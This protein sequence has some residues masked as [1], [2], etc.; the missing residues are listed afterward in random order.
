MEESENYESEIKKSENWE[1]GTSKAPKGKSYDMSRG[2]APSNVDAKKDGPGGRYRRT[3]PPSAPSNKTHS[4]MEE[5]DGPGL[6]E[7]IDSL[8][9]PNTNVPYGDDPEADNPDYN[10]NNELGNIA[11]AIDVVMNMPTN[12]E[13]KEKGGGVLGIGRD[14]V[15]RD[16][17]K[18]RDEAA[19]AVRKYT[20]EVGSRL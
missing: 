11:D 5:S 16:A 8:G 10:E 6:R 4:E 13:L 1:A 12:K 7:I 15:I 19:K 18:L 17:L 3:R 20:K 14:P 2:G 9:K